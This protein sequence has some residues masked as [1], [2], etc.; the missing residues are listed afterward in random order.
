MSG[1]GVGTVKLSVQQVDRPTCLQGGEAVAGGRRTGCW[2][3]SSLG[4]GLRSEGGT[5][6]KVHLS[7]GDDVLRHFSIPGASSSRV[8]P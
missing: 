8:L 7:R 4:E 1:P 3:P 2:H 6:E 5:G